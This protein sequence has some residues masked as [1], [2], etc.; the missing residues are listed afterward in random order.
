MRLVRAA[1][2]FLALS[3]TLLG[4]TTGVPLAPSDTT[5]ISIKGDVLGVHD[6]SSGTSP[7]HGQQANACSYCHIPHHG[8]KTALWNQTLSSHPYTLYG[9]G[10]QQNPSV[11]P[12]A[13]SPSTLCLSCHDGTVAVGQTIAIGQLSMTGAVTNGKMTN[14]LGFALEG[15]HPF[16]L[17]LPIKDSASLIQGFASSGTINDSTKSIHLVNGN[18]ECNTCHDVHN[19][20]I[21]KKSLNFLVRDNSGGGICLSCHGTSPRTVAGRTNPLD[22]WLTS[23]HATSSNAVAPQANFG[24]RTTVADY[25]CSSCHVPHNSAGAGLLRKT[26]YSVAT[27][28]NTS[29]SCLV[30]HDGSNILAQPIGNVLADFQKSGHPFA[31]SSNPHTTGEDTVLNHNRHTTCADCHQPHASSATTTFDP[32][33]NLRPSQLGVS[34]VSVDGTTLAAATKQYENCLRCHGAS[35]DQQTPVKYGYLP[36]RSLFTGDGLNLIL[37]FGNSA[38]SYHPVMRDIAQVS[39]SL[40]PAMLDFTGKVPVRPMGTRV[41]CTD[42]HNSDTNREFGGSGPNG[43]HGSKNDHILERQYVASYVATGPWPS[44]GPGTLIQ[45]PV[46][47]LAPGDARLTAGNNGPFEMCAK[48]HDL[49]YIINQTKTTAGKFD[50]ADHLGAGASCSVCHSAHGVP[51]GTANVSGLHLVS[52]DMKVVRPKSGALSYTNSN[53]CTLTCHMKDHVSN[54]SGTVV[55]DADTTTP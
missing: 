12:A 53:N 5:N 33:P 44:A 47:G 39:G 24:N 54:G 40:L 31:D 7:V 42:C 9:S 15:S 22:Q 23:S 19:Q 25:A 48:C 41:F 21:D 46:T 32:A 50:H 17:Q 26:T 16:S 30:C 49:N 29:K 1:L 52:F 18:I 35:T 14:G 34:G 6:F 4:Q 45:N 20:Y 2:I 27:D 28:D 3:A 13:G 36:A 8:N 38:L 43:P 55:T 11:Q 37:Q 51:Q 10:T